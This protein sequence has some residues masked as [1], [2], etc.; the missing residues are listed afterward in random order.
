MGPLIT[1][2]F[3][4]VTL[5]SRDARRSAQFYR[6]VL[7]LPVAG[8]H[9]DAADPEGEQAF[10]G[11]APGTLVSVLEWPRAGQGAA[12]I[13][14]VHHTAFGVATDEALLKW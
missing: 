1:P 5:V 4:H 13:G 10:Y 8:T 9:A 6:G 7:G 11:G 14:G 3:H 12:G 2:G